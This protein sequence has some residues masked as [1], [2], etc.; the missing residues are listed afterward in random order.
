MT[1]NRRT[2]HIALGAWGEQKVEQ[3]Y[4]ERGYRVLAR[5][6]R[7]KAGE[8]DLVVRKSRVLVTCEVKTRSSDRFGS[9]LESVDPRRVQRLQNATGAYLHAE[10]PKGISVVRIDLAA[11]LNGNITVVEAAL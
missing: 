7:C 4:Q 8:L 6:W 5:N 1:T 2:S 9:P 3:W 11:V 10:R